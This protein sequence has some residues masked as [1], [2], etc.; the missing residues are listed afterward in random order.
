MHY[1]KH[2]VKKINE[3]L[4]QSILSNSIYNVENIKT[5]YI[6][7]SESKKKKKHKFF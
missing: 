5:I 1:S 2:L 3:G 7:I 6:Y 4:D